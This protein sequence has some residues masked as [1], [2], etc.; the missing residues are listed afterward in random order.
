LWLVDLPLAGLVLHLALR[1]GLGRSSGVRLLAVLHL[2]LAML[3]AAFLLYGLMS[4]GVVAGALA[5]IGLAPLHLAVIGYFA[6]MLLGMV[7]RVSL[8]HSGRALEA[9]ALT[10]ACYVGVLAAAVL[11][12]LAEL[13]RA[14]PAGVPLMIAA[15]FVW[16]AAFGVWAWR[17][18]P[19]YLAPRADA[20]QPVTRV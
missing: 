7:S 12:A 18:A 13:V 4:L 17:Y 9:D 8:G 20:P 15:G 6:A 3:A 14:T 2:S 1:W 11:R 10:W 5:R 19:M 16:L